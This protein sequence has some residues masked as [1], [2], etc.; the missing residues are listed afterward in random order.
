MFDIVD[1]RWAMGIDGNNGFSFLTPPPFA[2]E[3]RNAS[4]TTVHAATFV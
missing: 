2:T 4:S 1:G 3:A